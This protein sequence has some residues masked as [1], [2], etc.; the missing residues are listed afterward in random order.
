VAETPVRIHINEQLPTPPD[1]PL[2]LVTVSAS[3]KQEPPQTNQNWTNPGRWPTPQSES[4]SI[5]TSP[6]PLD[7]ADNE[8]PSFAESQLD[9]VLQESLDP[10]ELSS[11]RFDH[12]RTSPT[13]SNEVEVS[14]DDE[15]G[16]RRELEESIR[17][18]S[19]EEVDRAEQDEM[20]PWDT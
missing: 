15:S 6:P 12:G 8:L 18:P 4:E 2:T 10:L 3:R 16:R 5:T 7:D 20:D 17:A 13:S 1:E 19:R 11:H 14:S 9:D